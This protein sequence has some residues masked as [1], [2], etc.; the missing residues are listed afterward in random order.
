MIP[1]NTWSDSY[2]VV[3]AYPNYNLNKPSEVHRVS[4]VSVGPLALNASDGS[5]TKRFWM[6]TQN[7]NGQVV[8]AGAS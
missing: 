8:I 7:I 4:A 3:D 5:L 1:N 2:M 6:V